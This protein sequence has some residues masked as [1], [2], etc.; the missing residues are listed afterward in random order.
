MKYINY[1][2]YVVIAALLSLCLASCQEEAV[3]PLRGIFPAP[4][5][6]D[7]NTL[8]DGGVTEEGG[9]NV[10]HIKM[11]DGNNS[12]VFGILGTKYFLEPG[13]YVKSQNYE[14]NSFLAASSKITLAG[15]EHAIDHG[16]LAVEKNN[17]HYT[18]SAML[19]LDDQT[20]VKIISEGELAYVRKPQT[21][22]NVIQTDIKQIEGTNLYQVYLSIGDAGVSGT[23]TNGNA[24]YN[25]SGSLASLTLITSKPELSTGVYKPADA[26]Y[27]G[28]A[29][30][31][32]AGTFLKGYTYNYEMFGVVLPVP[33]F[34][35]WT[36]MKDGMQ[37]ESKF[38]DAGTINVVKQGEEYIITI[39]NGDDLYARY[40]G[41]IKFNTPGSVA[42]DDMIYTDNITN[43]E[44]PASDEHTVA[45]KKGKDILAQ[46]V[47]RTEKNATSLAGTYNFAD[48]CTSTAQLS[49]GADF[50]G[51]AFGSYY[52]DHG[53]NYYISGGTLNIKESEGKLSFV[54]SNAAMTDAQGNASEKKELSYT[55]IG[56]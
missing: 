52:V 39:D 13:T 45:I 36:T 9:M 55:N 56:K 23:V 15:A 24:T 21:L 5:L 31:Y 47:F 49:K 6:L 43:A 8:T 37:V 33:V 38:I 16:S 7:L 4:T 25:G 19:W 46:F 54:L 53:V 22:V 17:D 30:Q 40:A 18:I 51:Y 12:A 28:P 11:S 26:V 34:S 27:N 41:P 44:A 35:L 32:A 2:H 10:F 50:Y 20:P 14:H 48:P 3:D 42:S 29:E 1:L